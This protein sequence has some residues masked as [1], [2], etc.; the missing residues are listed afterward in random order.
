M[1]TSHEEFIV[2]GRV[3]AF[4]VL[5]GAAFGTGVKHFFAR[6]RLS[7]FRKL[8]SFPLSCLAISKG[9]LI[10]TV[11]F[12]I[13]LHMGSTTTCVVQISRRSLQDFILNDGD[14][15]STVRPRLD[16]RQWTEQI[17]LSYREFFLSRSDKKFDMH[18]IWIVFT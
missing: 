11:A 3:H 8:I 5:L 7:R 9:K 4:L 13:G 10:M 15:Y 16:K 14:A 6:D 2:Q 18:I 17:S 12:S 1:T